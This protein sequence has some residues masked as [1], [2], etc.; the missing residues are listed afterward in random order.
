MNR[1]GTAKLMLSSPGY[2]P[3]GEGFFILL[4]GINQKELP[5]L[6]LGGV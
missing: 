6:K 1:G 5:T 2:I 4:L 3:G